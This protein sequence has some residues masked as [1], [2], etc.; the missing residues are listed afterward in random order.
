VILLAGG[1]VQLGEDARHVALHG[2]LAHEQLL[3]DRAVRAS[4]GHASQDIALPL[5][6]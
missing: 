5:G 1:E 2:A 4:L 3:G 6:Q